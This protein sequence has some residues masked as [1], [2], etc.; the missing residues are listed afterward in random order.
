LQKK[1]KLKAITRGGRETITPHLWGRKG[2]PFFKKNTMTDGKETEN[3]S[4][5]G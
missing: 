3:R 2:I 5:Q 1:E 4:D